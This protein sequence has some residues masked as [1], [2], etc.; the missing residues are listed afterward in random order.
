[1]LFTLCCEVEERVIAV[2]SF[3]YLLFF[4]T[5]IGEAQ[6]GFMITYSIRKPKSDFSGAAGLVSPT[7]FQHLSK[8]QL[9]G[10]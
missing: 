1:M 4:H 10:F 2:S 3:S 6:A 7:D 9:V 8:T 5:N